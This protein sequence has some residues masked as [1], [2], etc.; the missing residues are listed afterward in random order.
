M[1]FSIPL[2]IG[3][4]HRDKGGEV[5]GEDAVQRGVVVV[6]GRW[7]DID[8]NRFALGRRPTSNHYIRTSY[9]VPMKLKPYAMA[10]QRQSSLS[11][12]D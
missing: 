8:V 6:I 10:C 7:L 11:Y 9:G 1:F 5:C 4:Q 3:R 2:P 12:F